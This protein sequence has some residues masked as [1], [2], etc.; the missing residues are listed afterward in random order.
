VLLVDG[1]VQKR[2]LHPRQSERRKFKE[3]SSQRNLSMKLRNDGRR[4]EEEE[5]KKR[6]T[7]AK[8]PA[9]SPGSLG[10]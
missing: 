1:S 5:E 9:D 2:A 4:E 8:I 7:I 6:L 10:S 3:L